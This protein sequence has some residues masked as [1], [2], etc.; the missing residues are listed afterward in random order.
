MTVAL[1]WLGILSALVV[2]VFLVLLVGPFNAFLIVGTGA[3]FTAWSLQL[4]RAA[5]NPRP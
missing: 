1:I 4:A 5:R 2:L 3:A